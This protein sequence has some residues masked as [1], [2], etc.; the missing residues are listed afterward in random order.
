VAR[1]LGDAAV[2]WMQR[3]GWRPELTYSGDPRL[4][5]VAR[6]LGDLG[7]YG[8]RPGMV[9][10]EFIAEFVEAPEEVVTNPWAAAR[11]WREMAREMDASMERAVR[12]WVE[13]HQRA[14]AAERERDA[15]R[16]EA[17]FWKATKVAPASIG[18]GGPE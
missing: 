4:Y 14:N 12:M 13:E 2:N 6:G 7:V 1:G 18:D 9:A 17:K 10:I 5:P 11:W 8:S 3:H 15:Y 16:D